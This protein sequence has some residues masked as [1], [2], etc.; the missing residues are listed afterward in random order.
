MTMRTIVTVVTLAQLCA[1]VAVGGLMAQKPCETIVCF[2]DSN[3]RAVN[4]TSDASDSDNTSPKVEDPHGNAAGPSNPQPYTLF[5]V[6]PDCTHLHQSCAPIPQDICTAKIDDYQR[7]LAA[8]P[9]IPVEDWE[10][11]HVVHFSADGVPVSVGPPACENVAEPEPSGSDPAPPPVVTDQDVLSAF[12][13]IPLP[14]P[15]A[16]MSPPFPACVH[17]NVPNYVY[18]DPV[19]TAPVTVTLLGTPVT[20][21][22][23]IEDYTWDFGDGSSLTTTD[24]GAAYPN[25][26]V[27]HIYRTPGRYEVTVTVRWGADWE[28]PTHPRSAVPGDTTTTSDPGIAWA[29]EVKVVLVNDPNAPLPTKAHDPADACYQQ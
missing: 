11:G 29:H 17:L 8:D 10:A 26:T 27:S 4:S 3:V 2:G 14:V 15:A 20:V 19:D 9:T 23:R 1:T 6:G 18:V 13:Q 16:R 22:P 21:F 24:P 25:G 12:R 28:S 5:V 7:R